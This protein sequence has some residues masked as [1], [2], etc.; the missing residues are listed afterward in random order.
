MSA[1]RSDLEKRLSWLFEL[2][3]KLAERERLENIELKVDVNKNAREMSRK[4]QYQS[5]CKALEK[6]DG[7]IKDNN[8]RM[9]MEQF[10]SDMMNMWM[11]LQPALAVVSL[12]TIPFIDYNIK[13]V[14]DAISDEIMKRWYDSLEKNIPVS[15]P[16][17]IYK[18]EVDKDGSID[19]NQFTNSFKTSDNNPLPSEDDRSSTKLADLLMQPLQSWVLENKLKPIRDDKTNRY[20]FEKNGVILSQDDV[21]KLRDNSKTGIIAMF[22]EINTQIKLKHQHEETSTFS[23]RPQ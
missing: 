17:L 23:P 20:Q 9:G 5:F 15:L 3:K 21:I 13:P 18:I 6:L 16:E 1:P 8:R 4:I 14:T 7:S 22:N 10:S 2:Q 12:A 19:V 11:S